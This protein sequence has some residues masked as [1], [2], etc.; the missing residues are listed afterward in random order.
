MADRTRPKLSLTFQGHAVSKVTLPLVTTVYTDFTLHL[1]NFDVLCI[2]VAETVLC[3][4]PCKTRNSSG[5]EIA[6]VN[7]LYDDILHAVKIQ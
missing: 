6:N 2:S 3:A 5:D 7:F 1:L 4:M